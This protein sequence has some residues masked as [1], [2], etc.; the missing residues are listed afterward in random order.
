MMAFTLSVFII[1][2]QPSTFALKNEG[3]IL[4]LVTGRVLPYSLP[5]IGPGADPDVQTVSPQ[6]TIFKSSLPWQ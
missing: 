6:V 2:N 3:L 1:V 5:S 4:L